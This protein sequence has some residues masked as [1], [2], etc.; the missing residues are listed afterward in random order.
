[1]EPLKNYSFAPS[2]LTNPATVGKAARI[3]TFA[4]WCKAAGIDEWTAL[5]KVVGGDHAA[6]TFLR[7]ALRWGEASAVQ[8]AGGW[9]YQTYLQ[10][11]EQAGLTRSQVD[12][13]RKVLAACVGMTEQRRRVRLPGGEMLTTSVL[14]YRIDPVALWAAFAWHCLPESARLG[15]KSRAELANVVNLHLRRSSNSQLSETYNW[16]LQQIANSQLSENS[17]PQLPETSEYK[18][19][20]KRSQNQSSEPSHQIDAPDGTERDVSDSA[21]HPGKEDLPAYLHGLYDALGTPNGSTGK[22]LT[23]A[24]AIGEERAA[25]VAGRCEGTARSW[26]YVIEALNREGAV[27]PSTSGLKGMR[28]AIAEDAQSPTGSYADFFER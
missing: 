19:S 26:K 16:Q 17:D 15:L 8:Q 18:D 14:H 24:A 21:V 11:S 7:F 22:V 20:I 28:K 9:F 3:S 25:A 1:M 13:V 10:F 4:G 23:A 5:Q 12:R 2:N 27:K 6:M